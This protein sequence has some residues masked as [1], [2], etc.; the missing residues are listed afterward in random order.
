MKKLS[1]FTSLLL[2]ATFCAC[3]PT[4]VPDNDDD[5]GEVEQ[6]IKREWDDNTIRLFNEHLDGNIIPS[7]DVAP[8]IARMIISDIVI[9]YSTGGLADTYAELLRKD[10]YNVTQVESKSYFATKELTSP[11][12]IAIQFS[13]DGDDEEEWFQISCSIKNHPTDRIQE[14]TAVEKNEFDKY[15]SHEYIPFPNTKNVSL[16]YVDVNKEDPYIWVTGNYDKLVLPTYLNALS[17]NGYVLSKHPQYG[18][19]VARKQLPN[20]R[21]VELWVA[22]ADETL[23][24]GGIF[25]EIMGRTYQGTIQIVDDRHMAFG[26]Y[27]QTEITWKDPEFDAL[28]NFIG[29]DLS[30]DELAENWNVFN[31]HYASFER[32][33]TGYYR[34]F[35]VDNVKYRALYSLEPRTVSVAQPQHD[36]EFYYQVEKNGYYTGIVYF[37]RWDPIIW[38]IINTKD[39]QQT[40]APC[41]ILDVNYFSTVENEYEIDGKM[42]YPSNYEH[43]FMREW[44]NDT[45]Y[46]SAFSSEEQGKILVTEVKNGEEQCALSEDEVIDPE[47]TI[48]E[49][50]HDYLS[51][52]TMDKVF[53][54]SR[55]ELLEN[56]FGYPDVKAWGDQLNKDKTAKPASKYAVARG[57]LVHKRADDGIYYLALNFWLRTPQLPNNFGNSTQISGYQY[58]LVHQGNPSWTNLGFFPGI[59]IKK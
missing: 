19:D 31:D 21:Y 42:I 54:F 12:Y 3:T 30:A 50:Y 32:V 41:N 35:E 39:D 28:R 47:Y 10:G 4:I 27:P 58:G 38:E 49:D 11:K 26:S 46:N 2:C 33:S 37:F 55:K 43:S 57:A 45:F 17:N 15:L 24:G 13:E 48:A 56:D 16:S 52:D 53:L 6:E 7:L 29:D 5:S 9:D 1:V 34:D 23:G 22:I 36:D 51:P 25:F 40:L 59:N 20:N 18:I 8:K 44:M 14:W